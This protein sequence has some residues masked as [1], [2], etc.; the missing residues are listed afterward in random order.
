MKTMYQLPLIA[1]LLLLFAVSCKKDEKQV[2]YQGGTAPKL[3]VQ[4]GAEVAYVNASQTALTLTWTNPSY[5]FNTGVSSLDVNYNL[6]IDTAADFSSPSKKVIV[7]SKDLSYSISVSD[8]NDILLNQL[9]LQPGVLHTLQIR[10]VSSMTA[11]SAPLAS[12]TV[13]LQVTPYAIPPKVQPPA[14]GHLYIVGDATAGGWN[15]PVP[16]PAQEFTKVSDTHYTITVS[17]IGG[18][19]YLLIP[20]NGDWTHKYS[21]KDKTVSGLNGGGDFGLD[22]KDNFPGPGNSGTY[23][24]DVD[25]Q[26]GKFTVTPQ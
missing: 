5:V 17:L 21:V 13:Q 6:E 23:K 19:E 9:V 22:L 26:R 25:F 4:Q 7:V 15:N 2:I 8:L 18:K 16:M 10:V 14:S 20:V 24:I 12:N 3:T 11:S 1:I